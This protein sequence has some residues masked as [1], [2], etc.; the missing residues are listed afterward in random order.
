MGTL[1]YLIPRPRTGK[2]YQADMDV[3][4]VLISKLGMIMTAPVAVFLAVQ[5]LVPIKFLN[6]VQASDRFVVV[7][8]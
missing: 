1:L 3:H 5:V 7:V 8:A 6:F 4:S 2:N